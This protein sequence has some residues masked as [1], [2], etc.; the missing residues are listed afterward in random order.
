MYMDKGDC[1]MNI[2]EKIIPNIVHKP[3]TQS[4]GQRY[5]V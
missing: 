1:F 3:A 5:S 2:E 4:K